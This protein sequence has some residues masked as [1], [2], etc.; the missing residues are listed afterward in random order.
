MSD[1]QESHSEAF[2]DERYYISNSDEIQKN[3]ALKQ[4]NILTD[5]D[6]SVYLQKKEREGKENV[7]NW[8]SYILQ[9]S[10]SCG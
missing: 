10:I 6:I 4:I 3:Y 5:V 8:V 1:F 7:N 9:F 2:R